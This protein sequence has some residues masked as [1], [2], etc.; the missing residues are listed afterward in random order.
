ME[1]LLVHFPETRSVLIDDYETG[2]VEETIP[3]GEGTHTIRLG[4]PADYRPTSLKIR[5]ADT[6]AIKP[7]EVQF[8]KTR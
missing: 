3:V 5:I 4:G 2:N 1:F 6:T 8:E 7:M